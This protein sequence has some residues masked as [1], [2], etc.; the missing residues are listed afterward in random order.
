MLYS[1]VLQHLKIS[2]LDLISWFIY[3]SL[4]LALTRTL[5][6]GKMQFFT[7]YFF[8]NSDAKIEHLTTQKNVDTF[9]NDIYLFHLYLSL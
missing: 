1:K 5:P 4:L 7:H 8:Q 2:E 6:R 9:L 3:L